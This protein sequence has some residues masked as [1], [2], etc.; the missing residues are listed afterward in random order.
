MYIHV[1]NIIVYS[2]FVHIHCSTTSKELHVTINVD[3]FKTYNE[4]MKNVKLLSST[5]TLL[6]LNMLYIHNVQ[7]TNK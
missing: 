7:I 3:K 4:G 6:C 2:A 1:S 5:D